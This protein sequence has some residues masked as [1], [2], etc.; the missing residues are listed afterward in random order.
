V[1][2]NVFHSFR[3]VA[4]GAIGM[5]FIE[6]DARPEFT[7]FLCTMHSFKEELTDACVDGAVL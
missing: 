2:Q 7:Y 3:D 1:E 4:V 5:I 6:L